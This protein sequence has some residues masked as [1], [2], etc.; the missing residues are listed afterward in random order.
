MGRENVLEDKADLLSYNQETQGRH[1]GLSHCALLPTDLYELRN[2]L[3]Y[4]N[5]RRLAVVPQGARMSVLGSS[6]SIFD[7]IVINLENINKILDFDE[8]TGIIHAQAGCTLGE[9]QKACNAKGY[10]LPL[11]LGENGVFDIGYI[12]YI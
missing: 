7:E 8:Q 5:E 3:I 4:C 2:L 6:L 11:R 1:T 12:V 9:I 10:H